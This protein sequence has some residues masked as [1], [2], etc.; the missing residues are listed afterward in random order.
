MLHETRAKKPKKY[1][2]VLR[3]VI[4]TIINNYVFIDY[5]ACQSQKKS[6]ISVDSKYL[7]KYFSRILAI[8][9]PDLLTNLLAYHDLS[10]N[11]K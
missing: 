4:Y 7:E 2:I 8:G 10:K 11:I 6:E 5:L 1:F 3:C 9:I